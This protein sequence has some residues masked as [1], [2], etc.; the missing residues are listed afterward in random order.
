VLETGVAQPE[1]IG[2]YEGGL[3]PGAVLR[4]V[5]RVGQ[6]ALLRAGAWP[7]AVARG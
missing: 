3:P 1:S 7:Y 4:R 2:L 5:R 6:L